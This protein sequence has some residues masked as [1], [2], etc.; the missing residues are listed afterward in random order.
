M[1]KKSN[2]SKGFFADAAFGFGVACI[3]GALY[4]VP[5]LFTTEK[6]LIPINGK[7]QNVEAFYTQVSSR[8]HKSVKSELLL[9]LKE[10]NRD[11][12]LAKNIEQSWNN[13]KY[14]L[15]EKELKKSGEATIWIKESAK[16][17]LEPE[18]FQISNGKENILYDLDD[19][20][21]ELYWLFPFFIVMGLFNLGIYFH[22]KYPDN[23][24][25]LF[26]IKASAQQRTE[27]KNKPILL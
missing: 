17:D 18:V 7:V 4:F 24:K 13:E 15:I 21:S 9:N 12:K 26:K 14:E 11:Y 25:K 3:G 6:N 19:V 16:S 20:K 8:G 2:T 5:T 22:H 23:F 10:D 1:F 27:V